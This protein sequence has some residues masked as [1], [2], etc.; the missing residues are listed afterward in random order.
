MIILTDANFEETIKTPGKP[1][2]VDIYAEWCPPCKML[3]PIME[4]LDLDY[5]DRVTFAKMNLDENHITGN[6]LS[7]DRIPTVFLYVDGQIKSSFTGFRQE[8]EI[9]QWINTNI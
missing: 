5:R 4:K 8:N 3:G 2:L 1:I 6:A 7:V 9:K